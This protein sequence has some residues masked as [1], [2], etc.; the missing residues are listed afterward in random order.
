MFLDETIVRDIKPI[1]ADKF[2]VTLQGRQTTSITTGAAVLAAGGAT[3]LSQP[4]A[5]TKAI[6]APV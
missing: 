2:L 6:S 4:L 3:G 5:V 1:E